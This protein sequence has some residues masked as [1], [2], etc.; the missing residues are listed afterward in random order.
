MVTLKS[1][2]A[3]ALVLFLSATAHFSDATAQT[4]F[5]HLTLDFGAGYSSASPEQ[6]NSSIGT[7]RGKLGNGL[8]LSG[9]LRLQ[10]SEHFSMLAKVGYLGSASMTTIAVTDENGPQPLALLHD[11]YRIRSVPVLLGLG[12]SLSV[13]KTLLRADLAGEYHFASVTYDMPAIPA[14]GFDPIHAEARNNGIGF[15]VAAG[16]EW[17]VLPEL[18]VGGKLGYR[19]ANIGD[20]GYEVYTLRKYD[21]DLSGF[22]ADAGFRIHP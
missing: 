20:F 6:F 19:W 5:P 21:L 13:G 17:R 11:E 4:P 22:F 2:R 14:R 9:G 8:A 7:Q 15:S 16:P 18:S 1:L 3:V 12:Y 10:V